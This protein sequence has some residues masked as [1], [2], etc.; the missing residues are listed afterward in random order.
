VKGSSGEGVTR[1]VCCLAMEGTQGRWLWLAIH[2]ATGSTACD[3][4]VTTVMQLK[5]PGF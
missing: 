1:G 3:E 4:F 2:R 5:N